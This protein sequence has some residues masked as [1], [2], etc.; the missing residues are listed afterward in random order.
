MKSG[1]RL[2]DRLSGIESV[3]KRVQEEVYSVLPGAEIILY[4]SRARGVASPVSDWDF[5]ILVDQPLD[6]DL[7][8]KVRN[9]LYDL[10]LETDTVLS[11]IIR[12][13]EEWQSPRYSVLPFKRMVEQEGISL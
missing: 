4:G 5:L 12:T 7:I 3:L 6:R 2:D 8:R 13:R 9:R 11:S 1:G 10:E